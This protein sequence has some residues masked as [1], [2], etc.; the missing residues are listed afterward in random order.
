[1]SAASNISVDSNSADL[2]GSNFTLPCFL[3]VS[4][5][6][7]EIE[8]LK[9]IY[10]QRQAIFSQVLSALKSMHHFQIKKFNENMYP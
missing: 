6:Y 1:M 10:L 2:L 3:N 9:N 4:A 8:K 7:W 5:S